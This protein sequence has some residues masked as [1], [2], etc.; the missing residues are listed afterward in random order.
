MNI[1]EIAGIIGVA[2]GL[3]L[4]V[5]YVLCWC[6]QITWAWIDDGKCTRGNYIVKWLCYRSGYVDRN[7]SEF[8]FYT[9]SEHNRNISDGAWPFFRAMLIL[10]AAPLLVLVSCQF[11]PIALSLILAF[12]LA[13]IC[14]FTRRLRKKF[15]SHVADD[16]AHGSSNRR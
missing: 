5:A 10:M 4:I 12:G 2:L 1:Y 9:S 11:Y 8:Q 16:K 7:A 15:G 14:R 3:L 6:W 13:Y